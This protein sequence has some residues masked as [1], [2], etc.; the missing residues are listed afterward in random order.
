MPAAHR[1]TKIYV[2]IGALAA[3]FAGTLVWRIAAQ[4]PQSAKTSGSASDH[5]SSSRTPGTHEAAVSEA[6]ASAPA[7]QATKKAQVVIAVAPLSAHIFH[8]SKDLGASPIMVDVGAEPITLVARLE[9]YQSKTVVIDGAETKVSIAL[10]KLPSAKSAGSARSVVAPPRS[11]AP[12]APT[13]SSGGVVDPW[14]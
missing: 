4:L 11:V 6:A 9:G 13:N 14:K 5:S 12:P 3:L 10:D 8:G 2:V 7:P 1:N